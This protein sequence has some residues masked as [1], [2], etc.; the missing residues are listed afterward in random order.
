MREK[1]WLKLKTASPVTDLLA[2]YGGITR[3]RFKG[4]SEL[5]RT[6]QPV[7]PPLRTKY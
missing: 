6:S 5:L 7:A 1:A 4:S 3:I 2:P